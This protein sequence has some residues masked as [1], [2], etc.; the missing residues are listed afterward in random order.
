M[1]FTDFPF[2]ADIKQGDLVSAYVGSDI[3]QG[4]DF[5]IGKGILERHG[6]QVISLEEMAELRIKESVVSPIQRRSSMVREGVIYLPNGEVQ[7]TKNSPLMDLGDDC[8]LNRN[9]LE[10]SDEQVRYALKD[11]MRL[12][13]NNINDLGE[14]KISD[15]KIL[16]FLFGKSLDKYMTLVGDQKRRTCGISSYMT[17]MGFIL[18]K[19]KISSSLPFAKQI[20]LGGIIGFSYSP[21]WCNF[22]LN[23][24][25]RGVRYDGKT[26][27][28]PIGILVQKELNFFK[29]L[30]EEENGRR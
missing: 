21:I 26:G 20:H 16:N 22:G 23:G 7:I 1:R 30:K 27:L 10:L 19:S 5:D 25:I 29:S 13:T 15:C 12:D 14:V 6:Y 2:D 17:N 8:V 24:T 3:G 11:S 9:G 28:D 18:D 4:V